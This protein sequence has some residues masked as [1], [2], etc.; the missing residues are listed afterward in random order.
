[1]THEIQH[2]ARYPSALVLPVLP[3]QDFS[4]LAASHTAAI[5]TVLAAEKEPLT[6]A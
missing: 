6:P 3:A 2:N 1:V 5:Q 4:G